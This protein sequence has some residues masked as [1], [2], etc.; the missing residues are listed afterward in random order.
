MQEVGLKKGYFSESHVEKMSKEP[1]PPLKGLFGKDHFGQLADIKDPMEEK[2]DP[3]EAQNDVQENDDV[4]IEDD[5][6]GIYMILLISFK[7]SLKN[8]LNFAN[9]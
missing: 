5:E 4:P 9:Y 8:M 1:Q 6:F 7:M 3:M 2:N